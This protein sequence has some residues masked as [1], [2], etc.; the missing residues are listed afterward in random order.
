[1]MDEIDFGRGEV[2][3][4]NFDIEPETPL[5]D[6]FLDEDML[7]VKFNGGQ[8][9]LDAG[10]YLVDGGC[11]VIKAEG[12]HRGSVREERDYS[13][14]ELKIKLEETVRYIHSI[15]DEPDEYPCYKNHYP[16]SPHSENKADQWIG[17]IEVEWE[18]KQSEITWDLVQKVEQNWGVDL[19]Q[20]LKN[21]VYHCNGGG[22]IP[23]QF[24]YDG[25]SVTDFDHL[26]SFHPDDPQNIFRKENTSFEVPERVFPFGSTGRGDLC[27]DF[28][29]DPSHPSV[30]LRSESGSTEYVLASGFEEFFGK[31]HYHFGWLPGVNST[32]PRIL[33]NHL[34]Q[35]E[36]EWGIS[37]PPS[38]KKLVLEHQG[39]SP[40]APCFYGEKGRGEVDFLLRVDNLD[41]EN[42][43]R[44]IHQKHFHGT[45]YIP[46]A[47]CKGGQILCMDYNE[48]ESDP[49]VVVWDRT[50]NHF[51]KVKS[52]FGRFLHY[53][54]YQ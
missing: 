33:K 23:C 50:E 51:Y 5:E 24:K 6:Q 27:L 14:E 20:E 32:S 8:Y 21:I 7:L 31:L 38:Y 30:I 2:F 18:G 10:W 54:R 37:L 40:H 34:D 17:E 49:E 19:P 25:E 52:S 3:Y 12:D 48:K 22:P 11:F 39:G 53:L 35:M 9:Y 45:S 29:R 4:K 15:M 42:S 1:M 46:F 28:R 13:L 16:V 43:I 36:T 41:M 26:Y 44:S 47:Q